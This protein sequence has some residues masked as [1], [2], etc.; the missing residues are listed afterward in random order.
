MRRKDS[1]TLKSGHE[2]QA[3]VEYD[4]WIN[5]LNVTL[6]Q[7]FD[8]PKFALLSYNVDLSPIFKESMFIGF[9]ASTDLSSSSSHYVLGWSFNING[10]AK[11]LNLDKLRLKLLTVLNGSKKNHTSLNVGI[12]VFSALVVTLQEK[13]TIAAGQNRR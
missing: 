7:E 13:C 10:D 12:L 4:A 9:F 11:N 1:L 3:W 5:Q 8:R 2:I 6:A